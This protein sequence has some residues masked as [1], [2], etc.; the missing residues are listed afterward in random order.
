MKNNNC[1]VNT[2]NYVQEH[3]KNIWDWIVNIFKNIQP[4]KPFSF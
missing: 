2:N 4:N 3:F 1:P